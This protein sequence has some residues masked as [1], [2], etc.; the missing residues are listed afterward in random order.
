[1]ITH[2]ITPNPNCKFCHGS[3]TVYDI[4]DYGSTTASM[5]SDCGCVDEQLPEDFDYL[6]DEVEIV[7]PDRMIVRDAPEFEYDDYL[8]LYND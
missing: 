4:V 2:K 3:G 6:T 5:P 1:M 7:Q 8:D